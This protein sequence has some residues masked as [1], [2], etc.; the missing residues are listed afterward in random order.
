MYLAVLLIHSWLRYAVL[1]FGVA[2]LAV[3]LR[4]AR[5]G[6]DWTPGAERLHVRFLAVLD[7]QM[8]LGL[9]LYFWLSPYA[10]AA[11][12]DFGAAMKNPPLRFFGVEHAITM[13]LA[14]IVAHAGRTRSKRRQGVQRLRT[15]WRTQLL[16]LLLV[17]AAIPWPMLDIGRPLFRF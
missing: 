8:L 1:A 5:R 3:T 13:A 10:A 9:L 15:T 11:R 7:T 17:L 14:V 2:L 16:W 6:A 4:D 12:A